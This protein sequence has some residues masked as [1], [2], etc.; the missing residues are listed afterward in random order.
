[1]TPSKKSIR[2]RT[3]YIP[4][5][6]YESSRLMAASLKAIGIEGRVLPPSDHHTVALGKKHTSGD[7]CYPQAI[8][9]GGFLTV[10]QEPGFDPKKAAFLMPQAGGPCR[11]GQYSVLIEKILKNLGYPEVLVFSP[12]GE[13]SYDQFGEEGKGFA[14]IAWRAVVVSDILR[15]LTLKT[16][17]YEVE[18][19]TTDR[20]YQ[21][22]LDELCEA[23]SCQAEPKDHMAGLLETLN[24]MRDRFRGIPCQYDRE[25]PL[26]GVVGEI[27]CR[28]DTFANEEIVRVIEAQGGEAWMADVSEWIW[29]TN[30]RQQ[31]IIR[32]SDGALSKKMLISMIK[33][34]VQKSD[35]HTMMK[36][37]HEDFAGY[38]EPEKA[39]VVLKRSLPYLPYYGSHGEMTMST[40]KA[41][42]LYEKGVDGI[43]DVSPFTCMNG[44]I[45]EAIYPK[46]SREHDQIPI[47]V[48]YF[49]G[50][51]SDW[52][53]DIGIFVELAR[54]YQR[55]KKRKRVYP[56]YFKNHDLLYQRAAG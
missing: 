42:Y 50:T 56:R 15:K 31:E 44:I 29:Y 52:D 30:F 7:E 41:V 22:S 17:P 37:F 18:R 14:R 40:G 54:N 39:E 26:I 5:M 53:R 43:I 4:R 21:Q 2:G 23:M 24:R 33:N 38:E 35:E 20:V 9:L 28:L 10:L 36:I 34:R 32:K 45:C 8:T 47:K 12:R 6:S 16:R 55:N 27:Y 1:M 3:V 25:R 51:R 46:V 48:F 11:F 49:D 13:D 19:G